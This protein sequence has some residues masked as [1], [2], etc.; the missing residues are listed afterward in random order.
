MLCC[1]LRPAERSTFGDAAL[2]MLGAG[3]V[4]RLGL[5]IFGEI[6]TLGALVAGS[7]RSVRRSILTSWRLVCG[8]AGTPVRLSMRVSLR[9][10]WTSC[11]LSRGE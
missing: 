1:V 5:L 4:G 7:L 6:P 3:L 2:G 9:S 8:C 10:D 11:R